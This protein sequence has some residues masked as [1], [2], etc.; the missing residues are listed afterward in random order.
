MFDSFIIKINFTKLKG[1]VFM[2]GNHDRQII[3]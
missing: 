2:C 3:Q 1:K